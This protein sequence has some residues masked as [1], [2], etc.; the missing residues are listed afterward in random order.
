MDAFGQVSEM[1]R[2]ESGVQADS[3]PLPLGQGIVAL[4][5]RSVL[6]QS[7]RP[8]KEREARTAVGAGRVSQVGGQHNVSNQVLLMR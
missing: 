5:S 6:S 8:A 2:T 7:S 4:G 1:A 3:P